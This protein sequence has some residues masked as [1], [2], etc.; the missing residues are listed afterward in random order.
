MVKHYVSHHVNKSPIACKIG[1]AENGDRLTLLVMKFVTFE[2]PQTEEAAER[3]GLDLTKEVIP[4]RHIH[5]STEREKKSRSA[6]L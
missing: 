1:G 2:L 3:T 6:L 4:E 5:T